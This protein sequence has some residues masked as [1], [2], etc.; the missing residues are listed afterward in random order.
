MVSED[1]DPVSYLKRVATLAWHSEHSATAEQHPDIPARVLR[2]PSQIGKQ[3]EKEM[4]AVTFGLPRP[5]D[6]LEHGTKP[7]YD[8]QGQLRHQSLKPR[9][10]RETKRSSRLMVEAQSRGWRRH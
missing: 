9:G 5:T 6:D 3:A 2:R 7:S 4:L 1:R 10:F 8:I